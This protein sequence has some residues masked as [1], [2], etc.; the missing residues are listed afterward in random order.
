MPLD[1]LIDLIAE[2]AVKRTT[3]KGGREPETPDAVGLPY[4]IRGTFQP[5]LQALRVFLVCL[6]ESSLHN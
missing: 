1:R 2:V 5:Q 4:W 3:Q 6:F